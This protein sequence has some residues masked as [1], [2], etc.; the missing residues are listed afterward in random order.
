MLGYIGVSPDNWQFDL[1][2]AVESPN[3][4]ITQSLVGNTPST[5]NPL[6]SDHVDNRYEIFH[7]YHELEARIIRHKANSNLGALFGDM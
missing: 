4:D 2:K 3:F 1:V 7:A 5:L 6:S